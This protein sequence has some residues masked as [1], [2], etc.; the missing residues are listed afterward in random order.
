[1]NVIGHDGILWVTSNS[2]PVDSPPNAAFVNDPDTISDKRLQSPSIFLSKGPEPAQ[3]TFRNNFN[4]EDGFDGGVLEISID[5]GAT[6]QDILTRGTFVS[7]GY[8]GMINDCRGNPLAGRQAWTGNS[9]GFITTTVSLPAVTWGSE[10]ILRWRMGS[11]TIFAGEGWRIDTLNITQCHKPIQQTPTPTAT[12]TATATVT[13]TSTP[14]PTH[15]PNMTPRPRPT[16][17]P[18]PQV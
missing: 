15:R 10:M 9:G 11:D 4:L 8:T 12:T 5:G 16:L 6:F 1:M 14:T 7:G 2:G 3:I 18:R 17:P 13:P